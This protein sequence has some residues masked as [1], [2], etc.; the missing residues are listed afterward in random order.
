MLKN[1]NFESEHE[2]RNKIRRNKN[3]LFNF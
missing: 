1:K 2:G 3:I